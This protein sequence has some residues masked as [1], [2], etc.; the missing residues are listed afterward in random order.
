[1]HLIIPTLNAGP[2]WREVIR[3]I[4]SQQGISTQVLVVDSDST[5]DTVLWA[6]EAGWRVVGIEPS[7]FNHGGTRQWAIDLLEAKS[8]NELEFVVFLTQD[9]ILHGAEAL[10]RLMEPFRDQQV[11]GVYGRQL[12]HVNATP[13]AASL[14]TLHYPAMSLRKR[15]KDKDQLGLKTAF[16][17]NSF[18]AYRI[19]ALKA[20]GGFP[21]SVPLGE[22]MYVCAKMLMAGYEIQY[23]AES[24]VMHSHNFTYREEFKRYQAT[25]AFHAQESWLLAIFGGVSHEG[26]T[27]MKRQFSAYKQLQ[28]NNKSIAYLDLF[29]RNF[30]KFMA[31]YLGR[32]THTR[33]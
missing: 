24:M 5:D 15:F 30:L 28:S 22:D 27:T 19:D 4:Q 16:F 13:Y 12:P 10:M 8:K 3:A 7:S 29:Y 17:S 11:A 6:Q 20:I 2:M 31:Y 23:C 33:V 32:F 18:G 25:G 14:R 21:S 26:S 9:A 1:M